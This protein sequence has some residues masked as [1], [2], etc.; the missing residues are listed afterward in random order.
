[1]PKYPQIIVIEPTGYRKSQILSGKCQGA[2]RKAGIP[3]SE[4]S[5]FNKESKGDWKHRI[6]VA[7]KWLTIK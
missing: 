5:V 4:I 2:L 1:M 7:K 3:Q 6:S